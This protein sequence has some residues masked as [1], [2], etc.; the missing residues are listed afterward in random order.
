VTEHECRLRRAFVAAY[1]GER[2]REAT[3]ESLAFAWEPGIAYREWTTLL[4]TC[5]G[6]ARAVPDRG[7]HPTFAVRE[8]DDPMV[9]PALVPALKSLSAASE[10]PRC[11]CTASDGRSERSPN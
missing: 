9:E 6:W 4:D 11:S 3:A 1:G 8:E 5:S 7:A 2:G 10:P